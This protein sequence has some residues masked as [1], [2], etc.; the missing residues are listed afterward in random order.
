L[1]AAQRALELART[2]EA[3]PALV[4][5]AEGFVT[6]AEADLDKALQERD[7]AAQD[8][9]L[10]A[11]LMDLRIEQLDS[12]GNTRREREIDA[13]FAQA[14][15]DYGVDLEA[16]DIVPALERLRDRGIDREVALALDDWGRLRRR[17]HGLH[18]DLAE[19][20]LYLAMDLDPDPE[21]LRLRE[22][23]FE[24]DKQAL[25]ELAAPDELPKLE[26][27][28][29]WVLSATLWDSF[30]EERPT[31]YRMYDQA[32]HLYPDDFILQ[33]IG[34]NIYQRAGR[35]EAALGCRLVAM[36]LQPDR[37]ASRRAVAESLLFLGRLTDAEGAYRAAIALDP[38]SPDANYTLGFTQLLLGE[39]EAALENIRRSVELAPGDLDKRADLDSLR[40]FLGLEPR[41]TLEQAIANEPPSIRVGT[42]L[43]AFLD[44]PDPAQRDP[45][46]VLRKLAEDASYYGQ[47]DWGW[48]VEAVARVR[49][50]DWTGALATLESRFDEPTLLLLSPNAFDFLRALVH[51]ELGN[52]AA[53][54]ENYR[55][56]MAEWERRTGGSPQAWERS[57]VMRW[58][59]AAEAALGV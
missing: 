19:N 53:A 39:L 1:A 33:S 11:R 55:R 25:L 8:E 59:R 6:K 3:D 44:H 42:F 48:V 35:T 28:S 22:A 18:S 27:G 36:G 41:S 56:G 23:I 50:E 9:R 46:L 16:Q 24:S 54:W 34:G 12:V 7:L 52:D 4:A 57:D 47:V 29:I 14:F 17:V 58:R 37:A 2:G 15:H 45:E 21:R 13:D 26:P 30:P 20:T 40:F 32:L 5:R 31:V 38:E 10:L 43:W 49:L 51:A